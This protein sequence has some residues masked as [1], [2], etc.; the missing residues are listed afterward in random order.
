MSQT[1]VLVHGTYHGAWC[2]RRVAA[3]LRR[4][5]HEVY[6][7]TLTGLG[8]RAHLLGPDVGLNTMIADVVGLLR[9]EELDD[10]VLVGHSFGAHPVLGVADVAAEHIGRIVLLDG[11]VVE[12]G[13]CGF[14]GLP[15]ARVE[16]LEKLVAEQG[17]GLVMPA[18]TS[19]AHFGITDPAD[20]AWVG[21]RLTSHP[22]RSYREPLNLQ[23]E[24]G[25][26]RPVCFVHCTD[27]P[28]PGLEPSRVLVKRSDFEQREIATG[29]DAMITAPDLTVE[30]LLG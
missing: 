29:H 2:W 13:Q 28:M 11:L 10:V 22:V 8:E 24:Q 18:P 23:H 25:N 7:P 1:F 21:R 5:G 3:W 16:A 19:G 4:L 26:G 17:E 15:P 27:P 14:D 12:A 20:A 9:T 6:I 30:A